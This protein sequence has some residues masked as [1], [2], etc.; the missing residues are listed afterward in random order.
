MGCSEGARLGESDLKPSSS[1]VLRA[2]KH[3]PEM[4]LFKIRKC[5]QDREEER[6]WQHL[7]SVAFFFFLIYFIFGYTESLFLHTG[8]LKLR[9][10]GATLRC[11]AR[12]SLAPEHGL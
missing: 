10:A 2:S 11:G 5:P 9:R 8:F 7:D 3:H 12:S 1:Q 4:I 6:K